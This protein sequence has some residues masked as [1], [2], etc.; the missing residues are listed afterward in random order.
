[1]VFIIDQQ[2]F[3]LKI[4]LKYRYCNFTR[5][6]FGGWLHFVSIDIKQLFVMDMGRSRI[7]SRGDLG[8]SLEGI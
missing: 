2:N 7:L 5:F 1:M 3:F 6:L 4:F 8:F